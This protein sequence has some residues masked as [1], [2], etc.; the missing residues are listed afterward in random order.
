MSEIRFI[1]NRSH[2]TT[3]REGILDQVRYQLAAKDW[4][5]LDTETTHLDPYQA[6]PLLLSIDNG[7]TLSFVIDLTS[8]D[9]SSLYPQL[10]QKTII[11]HNYKYDYKVLKV[12]TGQGFRSC[13]D[14]M[15][16]EQRIMLGLDYRDGFR[17]GLDKVLNR[18]LNVDLP[19]PKST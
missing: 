2:P 4:V 6:V 16:V 18:R 14:T 15:V 10:S 12:Y 1:T 13:W 7:S 17:Y 11:A 9:I 5:A 19:L 3:F 8:V